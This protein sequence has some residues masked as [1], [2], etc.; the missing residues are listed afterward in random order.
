[1]SQRT[2]LDGLTLAHALGVRLEDAERLIQDAKDAEARAAALSELPAPVVMPPSPP[3]IPTADATPQPPMLPAAAGEGTTGAM[4]TELEIEVETAAARVA[5][6]ESLGSLEDLADANGSELEVHCGK[7]GLTLIIHG[8]RD[9]V[10]LLSRA[11]HAV[12][13]PSDDANAA[14]VADSGGC[15]SSSVASSGNPQPPPEGLACGAGAEGLARSDVPGV[16]S[17]DMLRHSAES[18]AHFA[19]APERSAR[20]DATTSSRGCEDLSLLLTMF[21][22]ET[23][24][25]ILVAIFEECEGDLSVAIEHVLELSRSDETEAWSLDVFCSEHGIGEQHIPLLR[26][27]KWDT[28]VALKA[29]TRDA[30]KGVGLPIGIIARLSNAIRSLPLPTSPSSNS[31]L[32][33][34][35]PPSSTNGQRG[36]Y[37]CDRAAAQETFADPNP[38]AL[39]FQCT[40]Y[41]EQLVADEQAQQAQLQLDSDHAV[42]AV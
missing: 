37:C 16:A 12:L 17:S 36:D 29:V 35:V 30:M 14:S 15:V 24:P 39:S 19:E 9:A 3:L 34:A 2:G 18:H 7:H 1:M 4:M 31:L 8:S 6:M 42:G 32:P 40:P 13:E 27:L 41:T 26:A 5:L 28:P 33:T 38:L 20:S 10:T 25:S 22:D 21:D 11:A 23:E